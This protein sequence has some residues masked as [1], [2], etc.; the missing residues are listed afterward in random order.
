M[1]ELEV[2]KVCISKQ[3]KDS[4]NY[5][6]FLE[7]VKKKK[8]KVL[9][10]K[11]G[12]RIKIENN[13][14]LNMLW[15]TEENIEQDKS[16][17]NNS[18]VFNLKYKKINI[19]FTGDIEKEAEYKIIENIEKENKENKNINIEALI[20]KVP[21]H[22]SNTSST[23]KFLDNIKPKI[24]IIGVGENNIFG[25]PSEKT[26]NKLIKRNIKIYRTDI[27]GEITIEV[28]ENKIKVK[29]MIK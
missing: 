28:K 18:L 4:K 21:H 3:P 14:Y 23:E 5:Q 10:L 2:N 16:L 8:I 12:D 11:A 13:L 20:L 7:I 1:E 26:I 17:N 15:P 25:H 19:I 22:G 6:K 24:A 27:N 9:Y 29:T